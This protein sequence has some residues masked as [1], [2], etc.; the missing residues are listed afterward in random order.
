MRGV[1][2]RGLHPGQ[3]GPCREPR[4]A[5]AEVHP[6]DGGRLMLRRLAAALLFVLLA[7]VA[8]AQPAEPAFKLSELA[9]GVWAANDQQGRAGANAGF[10]IGRDAVAVVDS[11]FRP[12][13][14]RALLVEIRKLTP[15]PVR[16]VINTHHHIDHVGGNAV[17]AEAGALVIGH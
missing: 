4:D 5:D 1:V 11:F 6:T 3:S 2:P 7:A 17:L 14:T 9:P 15:L 16:F 10:V 13:A 8:G 12:E